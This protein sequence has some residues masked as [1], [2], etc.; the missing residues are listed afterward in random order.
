MEN[1]TTVG[2][3]KFKISSSKFLRSRTGGADS[4]RKSPKLEYEGWILVQPIQ[5]TRKK[6]A[7]SDWL[8]KYFEFPTREFCFLIFEYLKEKNV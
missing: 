7:P 5:R 1:W 4:V 3:R 8:E 2:K 6:I